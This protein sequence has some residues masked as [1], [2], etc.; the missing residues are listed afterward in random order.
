M[1]GHPYFYF[2]EYQDDM[3]AALDALREREFEAGRYN[4]VMRYIEFSEP[5]FSKQKP[6]KK[7]DSIQ[8]AIDEVEEE[9]TRSILDIS[10]V[11]EER[12]Y[13]VAGPIDEDTRRELFGTDKPTRKQ[14]EENIDPILDMIERGKAIAIVAWEK[15]KPSEI[16]FAGYSYD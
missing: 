14:I 10:T 6:G 9:G 11:G 13:G 3:Q 1:G 15:K 12:E 5:A 2:V 16:F 4:P 8:D 7:H